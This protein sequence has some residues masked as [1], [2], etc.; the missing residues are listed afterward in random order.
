[1]I[2]SSYLSV[3]GLDDLTVSGGLNLEYPIIIF[4]M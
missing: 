2:L 1:M 3:G 4:P